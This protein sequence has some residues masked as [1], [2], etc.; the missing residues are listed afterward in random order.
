M[1]TQQKIIDKLNI[2]LRQEHA[3]AIRYATH[4]ASISG[5]ASENIRARLQE[6]SGD[7]VEHAAKLR[8]RIIALGGTP[9]MDVATED[10]KPAVDLETILAVNIE[11]ENIAIATY[12]ELL[13]H[14]PT[15]NAILYQ[16]IWDIIRD[17]QEH[18]EELQNLK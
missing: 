11:E 4:A 14:I 18:L 3:C 10:L 13:T 8:D 5:P 15:T 17:E 1:S 16:T 6:I 7:E 12:S 2:M 9:T